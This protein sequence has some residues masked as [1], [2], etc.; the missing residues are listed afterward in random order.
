M[1]GEFQESSSEAGHEFCVRA[2]LVPCLHALRQFH[3]SCG[4]FKG[5]E[6]AARVEFSP[7]PVA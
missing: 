4:D 1:W 3:K 7:K 2:G 6:C 5:S